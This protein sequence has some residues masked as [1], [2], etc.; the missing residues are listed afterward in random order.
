MKLQISLPRGSGSQGG[1]VEGS[2][3]LET[4]VAQ[5]ACSGKAQDQPLGPSQGPDLED[6]QGC[7]QGLKEVL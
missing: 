2:T 6:A 3:D 5:A 4:G 1:A 7:V